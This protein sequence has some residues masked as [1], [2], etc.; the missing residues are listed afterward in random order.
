MIELSMNGNILTNNNKAMN[1]ISKEEAL[2]AMSE[3]REKGFKEGVE[4]AF[5]VI[6]SKFEELKKQV[7]VLKDV[8][9]LDGIRYYRSGEKSINK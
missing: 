3:A 6:I 1:Y 9:Y 7:T 5:D 8:V 4:S 2:I